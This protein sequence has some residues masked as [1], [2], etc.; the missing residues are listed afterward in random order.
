[1]R[2]FNSGLARRR[3]FVDCAA[4]NFLMEAILL[5][6][7]STVNY[8]FHVEEAKWDSAEFVTWLRSEL[9]RR[10]WS[11][12]DLA[13]KLGGSSGTVNKWTRGGRRP[14]PDSCDLLA[15]LFGV[16]LD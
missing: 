16:D 15:D 5:L 4:G 1:M 14:S 10:D 9:R 8:S 3:M 13:R 11:E 7:G 6:K 12:A 2:A